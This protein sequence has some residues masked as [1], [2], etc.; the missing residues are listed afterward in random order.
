V[1]ERPPPKPLPPRAAIYESGSGAEGLAGF[2]AYAN[3][4]EVDVFEQFD[5]Y[6]AGTNTVV[7]H[8]RRSAG[9]MAPDATP[10]GTDLRLREPLARVLLGGLAYSVVALLVLPLLPLAGFGVAAP[11]ILFDEYERVGPIV[12]VGTVLGLMAYIFAKTRMRLGGTLLLRGAW[13]EVGP[14][15]WPVRLGYDEVE[16][17]ACS[18]IPGTGAA[19][20]EVVGGDVKRTYRLSE[21]EGIAGERALRQRAV[22][23]GGLGAKPASGPTLGGADGQRDVTLVPRAASEF[24]PDGIVGTPDGLSWQWDASVG[25]TALFLLV[26]LGDAVALLLLR[27]DPSLGHLFFLL[28]QVALTYVNLAY[29]VNRT[30]LA[31][32]GDMLHVR[33]SGVPWPGKQARAFPVRDIDRVY[34]E[35]RVVRRQ[36]G[37]T[38]YRDLKIVDRD[39]VEANLGRVPSVEH[40][41][42]LEQWLT[43]ALRLPSGRGG[44]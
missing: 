31:V 40:G 26:L 23:A 11:T 13:I 42:F 28:V 35:V 34:V 10:S 17:V 30:H 33:P 38:T 5:A 4:G 39:L 44:A 36:K 43:T 37:T 27:R 15:F 18:P 9:L 2:A 7:A 8:R 1:A 25:V 14:R 20:L 16:R 32:R 24:A 29:L 19:L 41:R 12:G 3:V 22:A 21:A 6:A